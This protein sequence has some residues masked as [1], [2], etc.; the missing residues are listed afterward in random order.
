MTDDLDQL[1]PIDYLV[2]E[3]PPDEQPDG[4]AL[5]A[6]RDLVERGIIDVLDL[7]FFRRA[8]DGSVVGV[9]IAD[10]GL[11][12]VD[13]S[14]FAQASSGLLDGDD[15]AEAGAAIEQG[16]LGAVLVYENTWAAPF[17]T[18]LRRHNAQ[19]VASG[20]IPVQAILATLDQ[21]EATG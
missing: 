6:L 15:L 2:V 9:N 11:E 19:L 5:T 4:T 14:L 10:A 3:F 21:L 16:R 12:G 17:A 13:V 8:D 1:G 20:R 7:A 18:A